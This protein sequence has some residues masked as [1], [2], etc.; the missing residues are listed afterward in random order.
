MNYKI[1]ASDLDKTLLMDDMS[2]SPE[3]WDA[4]E[5]LGKMG[6][7]FVPTTGRAFWEM[8]NELRESGLIR[9]F[10][11]SGGAKIYDRKEG[12]SYDLAL[13]KAVV[14]EM[15]DKFY[16]YDTCVII[17]AEDRS[18]VDSSTHN[19]TDY[20]YF[21]MSQLWV[22]Y[23][24]DKDTPIENLKAFAYS[25]PAIE[26]ICVFFKN[27][28]DLLEC[29]AYFEKDERLLTV[30]TAH[31]NIEICSKEAGKGNAIL[32]LAELLGVSPEQTIAVGDGENDMTMVQQTA[33]GLAV[34]NAQT[35][36][37]EVADEI[38]CSNEQHAIKYILENYI[39][40]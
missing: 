8:P 23:L 31:W 24:L 25:R 32:K 40:K 29:K 35:M 20:K 10:I 6:V 9:Y 34:S 38:I 14:H 27:M 36:L 12:K 16:S 7:E 5:K 26:S 39:E 21:N 30:Q 19:P 11:T 2:I 3:N 1:V 37:K 18:W 17:H 4:I 22:D 28:D 13:E 33:L 15:L